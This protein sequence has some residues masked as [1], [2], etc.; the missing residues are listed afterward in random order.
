MGHGIRLKLWGD[1]ACFTRPEMKVERVSYDVI[2]PSA[3]RGIIEAIYWK[4]AIKWVVDKIYVLNE[5]SFT[6][7]RR[8]EV[9]EKISVSESTIKSALNGGKQNFYLV[10]PDCRQQRAAMLLRDVG[11][12]VEA[13][14]E[15]TPKAG[16]GDTEEKHYNMALRRIRHGQCHHQPCFGAR[17]FPAHFAEATDEDSRGFYSDRG[18]MDLGWMLW[19]LDFSNPRDL[20]PVF[21]KAEMENGVIDVEKQKKAR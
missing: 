16:P 3:A 1:Y 9:S 19:D 21:F 18:K 14:F 13:H 7:V 17:E 8:N 20:R 6:N 12:I 10:A 11:Y 2:T 15:L 4:P 5:I